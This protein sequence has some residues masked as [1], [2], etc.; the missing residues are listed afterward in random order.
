MPPPI[1]DSDSPRHPASDFSSPRGYDRTVIDLVW[2][3]GDQVE[4]NDPELWRKDTCGAWMHRQEYGRRKSEFGW[5]ICDPG[6]GSDSLRPMQWQNYLD[7]VAALTR[8]HI[9]AD[10]LRNRRKLV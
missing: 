1:D 9:T 10:G 8:S 3:A 2:A 7:Q 5:E 4:G 6:A